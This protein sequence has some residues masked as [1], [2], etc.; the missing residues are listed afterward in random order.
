MPYLLA[1]VW[2][3]LA[4]AGNLLVENPN[5]SIAVRTRM[6]VEQVQ[7][8][9]I[10]P[11]RP[12]QSGDVAQ[13]REANRLIIRSQPADGAR[14]DLELNVPHTTQM[15]AVT[16]DG[17]ISIEGVI[18]AAELDTRHGAIR[19]ELPWS[20]AKLYATSRNPPESVSIP[21]DV[22]GAFFA[23]GIYLH[24][25]GL[26]NLQSE[27]D[28]WNEWALARYNTA[29]R[30][31][32]PPA[33]SQQVLMPESQSSWGEFADIRIRA[34][35]PKSIEL[36][37]TPSPSP[38]WI[39]RSREAA[40]NLLLLR[41]SD[42]PGAASPGLDLVLLIDLSARDAAQNS[43]LFKRAVADF[44][45][46]KQSADRLAVYSTSGGL[47]QVICPLTA[48][49]EELLRRSRDTRLQWGPTALNDAL[50]LSYLQDDLYR[51]SRR[52][53]LAVI[54]D[55]W[56]YREWKPTAADLRR[57]QRGTLHPWPGS[58]VYFEAL[59]S[60]VA[61]LPV[62]IYPIVIPMPKPFGPSDAAGAKAR[63]EQLASATRGRTFSLSSVDDL[64]SIAL[65]IGVDLRG[66]GDPACGDTSRSEP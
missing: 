62:A 57:I 38:S 52:A 55:G 39:R 41:R 22:P 66:A 53:A 23:Q 11:D 65:Q 44:A 24:R 59:R 18:R 6:G 21:K 28:T 48:N 47:F 4:A 20:I 56:D 31:E 50:V 10:S 2:A 25:V 61:A 15:R 43:A 42:Q 37:D 64:S 49:R 63:M 29:K 3:S 7:L 51:S 1:I 30:K 8:S 19:I 46:G 35:Q 45:N 26:K 13:I 36:I 17:S 16:T 33:T 34:V 60:R 5:G 9:I 27:N 54:T 14:I 12:L 40:E 32:M 58:Q